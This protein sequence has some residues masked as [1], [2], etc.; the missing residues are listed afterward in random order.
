MGWHIHQMDVKIA[1]LNG[2]IEEEVYI[3]QPEGFE[4]FS[5]DSHVCRL[6][7]ALYELKQA[8]RAWYTRID[9]YFTGLGFS[10]NEADP[11]L[12][13]IVVEGKLLII[14]LYVDDLILTGD[15]LL[16]LS[17]KKDLATEFEMKDLGLLHY[18]L[19]LEIWQRSGG[20]FVS[21]GKY[22]RKILEKFNMHGC[23][24]VDT[25][26]P[27]GWRKEDAT[28]GEE[29]DATVYR[30]LVGSLMYLVNTRPDKCYAVNQLSQAMVKPTKLFWKAGKHSCIKLSANPVFHDRSKHID[31]KYHHIRDCVQR[32]IMLLSYI[33][34]EDQDADILTKDLTRSKFEYHRGRI[35]VADNPYLVE[36]EC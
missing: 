8:P 10:K 35:G 30:Q 33:P 32:R 29:V 16:I 36:R 24:P 15:E 12:Y 18:F 31:I 5:S 4:V 23:K 34:T 13:Q 6:K 1:F 3:E 21:Q 25:P 11:N 2:V 9:I 20:L 17:C 28:S 7:R 22:A 26:L 19:G 14:V 27:G